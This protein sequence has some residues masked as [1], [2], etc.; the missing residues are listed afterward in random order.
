MSKPNQLT[1]STEPI[2]SAEA[3]SRSAAQ[4]LPEFYENQSFITSL[5]IV[6]HWSLF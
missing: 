2:P 6:R 4:E 3:D 1:N 5:K